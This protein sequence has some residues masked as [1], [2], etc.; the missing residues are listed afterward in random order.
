LQLTRRHESASFARAATVTTA[1]CATARR[2]VDLKDDGGAGSTPA[3]NLK[4][5][6]E[7]KLQKS[8]NK[9]LQKSGK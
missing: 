9:K 7:Q 1:A 5:K 6:R 3:Q 8:E 4:K 2:L